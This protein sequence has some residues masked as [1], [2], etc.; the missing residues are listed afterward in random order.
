MA[1]E[2]AID[3]AGDGIRANAI[4]PGSVDTPLLTTVS[5]LEGERNGRTPQEQR[6]APSLAHHP[7]DKI[8]RLA[9]RRGREP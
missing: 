5:E 7:F 4:L 1:C 2:L 9:C 3:F 6:Y 8:A